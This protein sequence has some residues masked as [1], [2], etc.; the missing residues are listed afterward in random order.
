M[1]ISDPMNTT[2]AVSLDKS[3]LLNALRDRIAAALDDLEHSQR[4][5]Q[6][7]ATHEETRA[8]GPKDMRSTEASYLARGLASRV[9]ELTEAASRL[10][11][12]SPRH[13][14]EGA[15]AG[16]TAL[17]GL[18]DEEGETS[19]VFLV[20]AGAGETLHEGKIAVRTVTPGSPIGRAVMGCTS[21]DEIEVDLPAG[22]QRFTV[23]W[24]H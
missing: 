10:A 24:V 19:V 16:L 1:S 3:A 18:E 2:S 8:E 15:R 6:A 21:G 22:R 11:S 23:D 7:G 20:P 17:I 13:Y 4:A 9:A 5:A 12:T 14:G